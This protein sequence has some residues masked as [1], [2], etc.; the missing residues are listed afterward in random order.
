M[1]LINA[2]K[3]LFTTKNV[4]QKRQ[5]LQRI[6]K[7]ATV[8][9]TTLDWMV[10]QTSPD[11]E[12]KNGIKNLRNRVHDVVTNNTYAAQAI[13]YAT[14]QIVGQGVRMQAQIPKQRAN[15]KQRN[16]MKK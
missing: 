13:R 6:Y 16:Q 2:W 3:G 5:N 12:W 8:D 9:R 15:Q 14:N 4:Y 7:A 10:S 11:Q 1:G